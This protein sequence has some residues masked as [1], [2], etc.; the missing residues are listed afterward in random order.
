MAQLPS[1][2]AVYCFEN[3]NKKPLYIG[4]TI[5]LKTRIR[6][7]VKESHLLGTKQAT[8][9]NAAKYLKTYLVKTDLESV[10]LESRLIRLYQPKFN[11]I[12][13]D[14][15]SLLYILIKPNLEIKLCRKTDIKKGDDYF[16]PFTNNAQARRVLKI[17]RGIFKYCQNPKGGRAC[18]YYH[19]DLCDGICIGKISLKQY[20]LSLALMK[21]FL[22]GQTRGLLKKMIIE[23]NKAIKN[24]DFESAA[25][26]KE[27]YEDIFNATQ[28]QTHLNRLLETPPE[29]DNQIKALKELLNH[30]GID[31][32]L[33]RVE[34]YDNATLNQN[35]TVG[36]MVVF[37][38]GIPERSDYRYFKIKEGLGDTGAM[39]EMIKRR[40]KHKEWPKPDL[41]VL[42]GGK[43]QLGAVKDLCNV[44]A[45]G[46]AKREETL[47]GEVAGKYVEYVL[48]EGPAKKLMQQMRDEAHRYV[49]S[50]HARR[51]RQKLVKYG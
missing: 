24:K 2:P 38:L 35:E 6:Q 28:V 43:G 44:A 22:N 1:L 40:L 3:A 29:L 45:V 42:D 17:A 13:K 39:T 10:L 18:F 36:G 47:V 9:I 16:G 26:Y 49:N 15:R 51:M 48:P 7:H 50:F 34:I 23:I 21:K 37:N 31:S 14:D 33:E 46:L 12:Q 5:H 41:I 20:K 30:L 19:L 8:F 25:A 27:K 32:S 11:S 4:K